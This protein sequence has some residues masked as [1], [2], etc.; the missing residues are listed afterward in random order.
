MTG[1][2]VYAQ[3]LEF[4]DF[5]RKKVNTDAVKPVYG[6]R[7]IKINKNANTF[8]IGSIIIKKRVNCQSKRKFD[9]LNATALFVRLN[10]INNFS[11]VRLLLQSSHEK[12]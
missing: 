6:T 8:E 7:K 10:A 5:F 2:E 9:K 1:M 3:K 4:L 11:G 12:K